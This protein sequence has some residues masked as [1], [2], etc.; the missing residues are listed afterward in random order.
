[1]MFVSSILL[2]LLDNCPQ[3][4][5]GSGTEKRALIRKVWNRPE[6]QSKFGKAQGSVL[7][8]GSFTPSC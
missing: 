5:V 6:V 4:N 8:D 1:M 3:V 2:I 7:F